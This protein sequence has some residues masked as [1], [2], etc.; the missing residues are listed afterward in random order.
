[1]PERNHGTIELASAYFNGDI[2]ITDPG[3]FVSDMDEWKKCRSGYEM[4]NLG[5]SNFL[6]RT[7]LYGDWC[8]EV[9]KSSGSRLWY[10]Q[11]PEKKLGE[12]AGDSAQVGVFLLREILRYNPNWNYHLEKPWCACWI[13]NFTG[14]VKIVVKLDPDGDESMHLIGIGTQSFFTRETYWSEVFPYKKK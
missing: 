8:C 3:Y 1:M 2:I 11:A 14:T 4:E 9:F 5:F 13:K 7:T 10:P 12:F 6:C